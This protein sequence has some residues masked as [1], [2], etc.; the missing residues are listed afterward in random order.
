MAHSSTTFKPGHHPN[1]DR[2]KRGKGKCSLA[3]L[4]EQFEQADLPDDV[5]FYD[6]FAARAYEDNRIMVLAIDM[7][8]PDAE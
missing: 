1:P 7:L 6:Y 4:R 5:T 2:R 8:I 3:G